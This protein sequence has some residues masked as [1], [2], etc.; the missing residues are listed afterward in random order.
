ML[1][2]NDEHLLE[3][4]VFGQ[5]VRAQEKQATG[6]T[7][8]DKIDFEKALGG[9]KSI[10][11]AEKII[12]DATLTKFAVFLDRPIDEIRVDQSLS[13]IGLDSL[14]S[15]EL[16]N[17]MVCTFQ[18]NLQTSE[19]G[20]GGSITALTA[21]VA[22]RSKLIPDEIRRP[23]L[24]KGEELQSHMT[25]TPKHNHVNDNSHGFYC[26]RTAKELP[27]HPLVDLD[28][29]GNDL[30]NSTGHFSHTREEYLELSRKA[31]D[32]AAPG[33]LGRKLYDQL[34][35][36]ADDPSVE[37]WIAGPL[38]KALHI[39]R[40]YPL[41]PFSNFLAAA[42]TRAVCEFKRDR[43]AGNLEPDFLG[44]RANCGHSLLWLF[45]AVREPNLDCDK[46][47]KYPGNEH[48]AVLRKGHL[49]KVPLLEG[50]DIVSYQKL[51]ATFK[52]ILDQALDE[53]YWTGTLTTDNRDNWASNRQKLLSL[54]NRNAR[55]L[56]TIEK[57]VFVLCLDDNSLVTRE[58]RIRFGYLGASFNR[59]HDK[60]FQILVTANGRSGSIFEH[61]MI[62][63]M[64]ISQLSQRLQNDIDTLTPGEDTLDRE[65]QVIVPASLEEIPLLTTTEIDV[66]IDILRVKYSAT[67]D[68]KQYTPHL[69]TSF[70]KALFL[71]YSAPIKATVDLTIQLASRLYFGYLPASWETVS[72]AHFHLGRPEIVQVVLRS[73]IDFCD[74]ALDS[75]MSRAEARKKMMHAAREC[76]AQIVKGGEGRNYFRLM[77]VLEV[78]SQ[79]QAPGEVPEI[80]SDPVWKRSYPRLIMQTMIETRLAQDPGYTMEDPESVW[81]NYTVTD[82]S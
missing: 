22:S 74:A 52:A 45:N 68:A 8:A 12:R 73:V 37:S 35:A 23:S 5:L 9:V 10:E 47:L 30:L 48:V 43:D 29:A 63:F 54:D 18:V 26:C 55:Y 70:G 79:E 3:N 57:S 65:S 20:G 67:T 72:T 34:R 82:D 32:L 24:Q 39:K 16:K 58:E 4:P 59:W 60:S 1:D 61:S 15:I 14:V 53:K 21:T 40:R 28:E 76:N 69:I 46:M 42:L 64:T 75:T 31:Y 19:L 27:R 77:D 62:D 80:F 51:K 44:E 33:G 6:T 38:L 36:N 56:N 71:Q 41:A 81:M 25:H 11:E 50:D 78:I 17:W 49:F 66:Q 7:R 13:T 2:A